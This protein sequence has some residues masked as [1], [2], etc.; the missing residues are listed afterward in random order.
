MSKKNLTYLIDENDKVRNTI[1]KGLVILLKSCDISDLER[2]LDLSNE[3]DRL[4]KKGRV[5]LTVDL[6]IDSGI[7]LE[8]I[9]NTLQDY[10]D[11]NGCLGLN[12][13]LEQLLK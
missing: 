12:T 9:N 6:K 3:I 13:K 10:I 8:Q 7:T 2:S 5:L 11:S 1:V 4:Y